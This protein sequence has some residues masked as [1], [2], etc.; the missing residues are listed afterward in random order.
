LTP[1]S[2]Q[3]ARA[4]RSADPAHLVVY[5]PN[6]FFDYGARSDLGSVGD[7]NALFAFHNYCLDAVA[8][9][10]TGAANG[11][12]FSDPLGLCGVGEQAVMDNAMARTASTGDGLLMDEWGNTD[13]T[14]VITRM[15]AEAD[16]SMM[17][18]SYWAYEDCCGSLGAV[19]K[20]G[21]QPPSAPGNL[22]T[23]VLDALVRPYPQV[24]AGTP[25]GWSYDPGT[26]AFSFSYS[27]QAVRGGSFAPGSLTTIELPPLDYPNGYAVSVVGAQVVS[28]PDAPHLLLRQ[29]PGAETISVNIRPG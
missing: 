5:E 28:A 2:Q 18:W 25:L 7:P 14:S 27:T 13:D 19:V 1:F 16:Q 23:P 22:N 9:G 17:G 3:A 29:L 11:Q 8:A 26:G 24:I 6:I 12:T 21:T 4:I 15:T 10:A 20:D